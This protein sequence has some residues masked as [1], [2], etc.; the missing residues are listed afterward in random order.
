MIISRHN[1]MLYITANWLS[2]VCRNVESEPP[3]LPFTGENI[4]PLSAN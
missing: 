4:V 3:L 2:E 1:D